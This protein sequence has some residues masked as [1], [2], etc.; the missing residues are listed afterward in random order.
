LQPL[1]LICDSERSH[2]ASFSLT[3]ARVALQTKA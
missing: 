3:L 1:P 2:R